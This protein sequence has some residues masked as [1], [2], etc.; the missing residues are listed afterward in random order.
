MPHKQFQKR[1][2]HL[3][4]QIP[5]NSVAII[6]AAPEILREGTSSFH[7]RQSS[8]FYYLTGFPEP[9]AIAV[10]LSDKGQDKFILFNRPRDEA[11]EIWTGR[12]AGQ[13]GACQ[14]YGADHSYP[15][16][17]IDQI[18]PEI[19]A[20]T[21]HIYCDLGQDT[22]FD[23]L[24]MGWLYRLRKKI[25]E[26]FNPSAIFLSLE[27]IVH[28]MRLIKDA[29]EIAVMR[30]AAAISIQAHRRAMKTCRPGINECEIEAELLY[31][32]VRNGCYFPAYTTIVGGGKNSCTLHYND[33]NQI[34]QTD[35]LVLIDA[36]CEYNYYT[37]DI[38]RTLPINGRF[39]PEQRAIYEIV[40][41]AQ[42]AGIN[43]V[44]PGNPWPRIQES[45]VSVITEGL[46]DLG[47]LTG[48]LNKLIAD[49]A[50]FKFYMHN[51]GHWLGLD[52]HDVG[53][54]RVQGKWRSL[55]PG[56]VLTVEPGIYIMGGNPNVEAKWWNIGIRIE[57]DVLV[58]ADGY[59]ILSKDLPKTIS[60][61]EAI[62]AH[63]RN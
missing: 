15:I 31:E 47:I 2:Q 32:F 58:T 42:L 43:E 27:Q 22:S 55:T 38:T 49:R 37:S 28:E 50:Y 14:D 1:R 53:N 17:D 34:L 21:T 40:L 59:D 16:A 19:L 63:S 52:T 8:D 48:S 61:I 4:Q 30:K 44:R 25:R 46:R 24:L 23:T 33:N 13:E 6:R 11:Q 62:M 3:M 36:G 41:Q 12:R 60:D 51:S 9:E 56:M 26:G 57:D 54:Y 39:T 35:E 29:E 5:S 10:L 45:I 20:D 7:Y 18:M